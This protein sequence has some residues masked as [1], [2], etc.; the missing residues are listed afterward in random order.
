MKNESKYSNV[1]FMHNHTLHDT[2]HQMYVYLKQERRV[3][4]GL[5]LDKS[6]RK[7]FEEKKNNS[8]RSEFSKSSKPQPNWHKNG[9]SDQIDMSDRVKAQPN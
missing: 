9:K 6:F 2:S 3:K 7:T 4:K 5:A 8:N 1:S